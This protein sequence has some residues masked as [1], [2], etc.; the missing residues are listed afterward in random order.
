MSLGKKSRPEHNNSTPSVRLSYIPM[1]RH[2]LQKVSFVRDRAVLG[3]VV[4]H[5]D[6]PS[7]ERDHF[8]WGMK[9]ALGDSLSFKSRSYTLERYL[10]TIGLR[11]PAATQPHTK[12]PSILNT[13]P[14]PRARSCGQT[15][16]QCIS[17]GEPTKGSQRSLMGERK[18]NPCQPTRRRNRGRTISTTGRAKSKPCRREFFSA[19]NSLSTV[20]GAFHGI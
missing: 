10:V 4:E 9:I 13:P 18:L 8:I 15:L 14:P 16:Y 11:D 7:T 3:A 12:S 5:C 19:M 6:N 20:R 17:G 2:S 1:H